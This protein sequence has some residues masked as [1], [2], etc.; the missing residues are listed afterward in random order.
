MSIINK[1]DT[2]MKLQ[3]LTGIVV[4]YQPTQFKFEKYQLPGFIID[5]ARGEMFEAEE[6]LAIILD[7]SR[8]AENWIAVELRKFDEDVQHSYFNLQEKNIKLFDREHMRTRCETFEANTI[9]ID[10][11]TMKEGK[12]TFAR[13]TVFHE[14]GHF[15]MH[16]RVFRINQEQMTLFD[17]MEPQA[18][19][20]V[21]CCRKTNIEDRKQKLVTEEDFREHQANVF[22][23]A[24]TMPRRI[25]TEIAIDGIRQMGCKEDYYVLP[26]LRETDYDE[27]A[28]SLASYM[29]H[30][31]NVSKTAARV[32]LRKYG[33]IKTSMEEFQE[34]RQGRLF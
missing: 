31:F 13:F 4:D 8:E 1:T 15:C 33:L 6:L 25:F 10:N 19:R 20:S 26:T 11:E 22:A 5:K 7:Y 28:D 21:I 17:F 3:D 16:P 14:D 34:S 23:A 2:Y 30:K 12:E 27:C 24:I 29:G 32:Q 9:L 18:P